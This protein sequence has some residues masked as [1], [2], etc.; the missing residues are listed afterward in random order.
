[1][2][3]LIVRHAIAQNRAQLA[4]SHADDDQRPLTDKGRRRLAGA[5]R[6]LGRLLPQIDVLATSPLV[7]ARE[8]AEILSRVLDAPHPESLPLLAPESGAPAIGRWIA[9]RADAGL[10]ALVGHEP[11]LSELV[12]WLTTGSAAGF[13]VLKK[14]GAC[15]LEG[16]VPPGP[17]DWELRWLLTPAQLRRLGGI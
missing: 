2:K 3:L 16:P 7:R 6:G 12:G 13:V 11:D 1:M 17:G 5:A 9:E 15:L 8:T 14:G 10:L 4:G